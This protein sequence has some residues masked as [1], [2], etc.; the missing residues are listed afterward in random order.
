MDQTLINQFKSIEP[1][2]DSI[3]RDPWQDGVIDVTEINKASYESVISRLKAIKD[4]SYSEIFVLQGEPGSGKSHLLWRIARS[5]E[6]EF[7]LFASFNPLVVNK[8]L[9]YVS[10]LQSVVESLLKKHSELKTKPIDHIIGEI[11]RSGLEDF[12]NSSLKVNPI[13]L[14]EIQKPRYKKLPYVYREE[15]ANFSQEERNKLM[16]IIVEKALHGLRYNNYL[17]KKY[18]RGIIAGLINPQTLEPTIELLNGEKL[19]SEELK[20][21]DLMDGFI[22]DDNIAFEILRTLF[23]LS[24]F[25]FLISIDQI[26]HIDSRLPKE[27][28]IRFFENIVTLSSNSFKVLF[29]LTVQTQ[30]YQK[31]ESFIPT[32]LKDRLNN[33]STL[34][35]IATHEA[36]EIVK[37]RIKASWDKIGIEQDDPF[38]P[39]EEDFVTEKIRSMKL[40]APRMVINAF[41]NFLNGKMPEEDYLTSTFREYLSKFPYK[42]EE[43]QRE[44]SELILT[45]LS[46]KQ[47]KTTNTYTILSCNGNAYSINNST[48]SYYWTTR[49]MLNFLKKRKVGS[50]LL[51]RDEVLKIREN[52]ET[53]KIITEKGIKLKYYSK[54]TGKEFIALSKMLKDCESGD[55]E[56]DKDRLANF[57]TEKLKKLMEMEQVNSTHYDNEAKI[58]NEKQPAVNDENVNANEALAIRVVKKILDDMKNG[59]KIIHLN[60]YLEENN[61]AYLIDQVTVALQ[62]IESLRVNRRDD[63]IVWLSEKD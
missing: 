26:E 60:R 32:H 27:Q 63:G 11:I 54:D 34:F 44:T 61:S 46:A 12:D 20:K 39:F 15:F 23:I 38:Y 24:P 41:N 29:L 62:S 47:L 22:V 1:F 45:L 55:L 57:A 52:T 51:I 21:L 19:N 3:V 50:A 33:K 36:L 9:T 25:P 59:K 7:F 48:R 17:P 31:W 28:I 4:R 16:P 18:L 8:E 2:K 13:I 58:I 6:K 37:R 49:N 30:T 35:A 56:I 53:M 10:I 5:A 42:R 43:M 40:K 14:S